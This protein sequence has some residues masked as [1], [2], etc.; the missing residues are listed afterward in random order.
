MN[1]IPSNEIIWEQ[2]TML[3]GD[4][5]YITS[6]EN[7]EYYYIYK[8]TDEGVERL[9]KDSSPLKLENKYIKRG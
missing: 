9:S 6:K 4:I 3:N 1:K 8:K 2:I 7:R 5:Y